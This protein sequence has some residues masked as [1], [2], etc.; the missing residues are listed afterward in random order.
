MAAT[1]P[2]L[3]SDLLRA[4]PG[5]PLVTFY[6]DA[7]G[8]RVELSVATYANW[9]AK[10]SSLFVDE[11]DLER[12]GT[13]RIDLPTHWLGPVF[14]GAAWNVGLSV[15]PDGD[16]DAVVC[17]PDGLPS[18]AGL[19]GSLPV[20]ACAL[21]PLGVRFSDPVPAGVHDFGIEVWSQPDSFLPYDPPGPDDE[22]V[23]GT[24][25]RDLLAGSFGDGDVPELSDGDRL[26]T[27]ANPT[28]PAGLASYVGPLVRG[29]STVWVRHPDP[30]AWE[31]RLADERAT[32][33]WRPDL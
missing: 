12:G 4:D 2:A 18:Y 15:V 22:A 21:A 33:E 1:F 24:G 20:V 32:V 5:R 16:A 6:D 13:L 28:T 19:A 30:A 14:L 17:G 3:L 31:R 10:T 25:Q 29:G 27:T 9:V 11:L 23:P 7:T 26:V 8:E